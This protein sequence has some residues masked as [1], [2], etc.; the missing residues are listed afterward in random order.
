M[1]R[2][3]AIFSEGNTQGKYDYFEVQQILISSLEGIMKMYSPYSLKSTIFPEGNT[4]GEYDT[5]G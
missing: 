2:R 4:R 3:K 1:T 5:R